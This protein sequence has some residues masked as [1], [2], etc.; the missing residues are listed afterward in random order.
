M[1]D[2]RDLMEPAS[3]ALRGTGI[4]TDRPFAIRPGESRPILRRSLIKSAARFF[5]GIDLPS[6]NLK[7]LERDVLHPEQNL[8]SIE[9][10][11]S[12]SIKVCAHAFD[13]FFQ[14]S[15]KLPA[16]HQGCHSW[17]VLDVPF[18][19]RKSLYFLLN[20]TL[21]QPRMTP[22]LRHSGPSSRVL[23][24]PITG[25]EL[26]PKMPGIAAGL[27]LSSD[28][29]LRQETSASGTAQQS[30]GDSHHTLA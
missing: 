25:D 7:I 15:T 26:S 27:P 3:S 14:N 10:R 23:V 17:F 9:R 30:S 11:H 1:L 21:Q 22:L 19:Y 2:L 18:F 24:M 4:D 16:V 13:H 5:L 6:H 8:R 20:S 28:Q 29:R 12:P